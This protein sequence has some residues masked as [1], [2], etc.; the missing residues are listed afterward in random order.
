MDACR[1][2]PPAS[3]CVIGGQ[4]TRQQPASRPAESN[5]LA[6]LEPN[7]R[8][9]GQATRWPRLAPT[10]G[11]HSSR[12]AA[13][14][15]AR[16]VPIRFAP[17]RAEPS[18]MSQTDQHDNFQGTAIGSLGIHLR[19]PSACDLGG[20]NQVQLN[21][22]P[23][24][25]ANDLRASERANASALRSQSIPTARALAARAGL[26]LPCNEIYGR[27]DWAP[28]GRPKLVTCQSSIWNRRPISIAISNHFGAAD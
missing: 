22:W 24:L 12:Y 5:A 23:S 17:I 25:R 11:G 16:S 20:E 7:F 9:E 15:L 19:R 14:E 6:R 18:L 26:N 3:S 27:F 4:L 10:P 2:L 8:L 28:G 1:H 21:K 13:R